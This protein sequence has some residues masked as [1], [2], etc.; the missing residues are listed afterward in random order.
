MKITEL[1]LDNVPQEWRNKFERE[2]WNDIVQEGRDYRQRGY[3]SD[4]P[5]GQ[6]IDKDMN[7]SWQMGWNQQDA[8]ERARPRRRR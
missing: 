7:A 6:Y 5:I 8:I 2:V 4:A 3:P 1:T